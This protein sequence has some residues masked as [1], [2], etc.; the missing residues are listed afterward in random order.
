M[1]KK[2]NKKIIFIIILLLVIVSAARIFY[3][4]INYKRLKKDVYKAGMICNYEGFDYKVKSYNVYENIEDL[5][6]YNFDVNNNIYYPTKYVLIELECTYTG[7]EEKAELY[8]NNWI[9][10]AG[11]WK[12]GIIDVNFEDSSNEFIP[13]QTKTVYLYT[14]IVNS[15]FT[16][17]DKNWNNIENLDYQMVLAKYPMVYILKCK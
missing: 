5:K 3:I 2:R 14:G 12:N 4:N 9:I 7:G 1:D 11:Q 17:K 10:Q 15:G 8:L 13:N 16:I 6:Q